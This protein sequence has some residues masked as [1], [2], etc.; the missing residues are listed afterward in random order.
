MV[1]ATESTSVKARLRLS[2]LLAT[3]VFLVMVASDLL[4]L[5]TLDFARPYLGWRDAPGLPQAQVTLGYYLGE[6]TIPFY[7]IAF[8]HLSLAIRPPWSWASRLV[9]AT[10]AYS[11]CL[12]MVWHASFAFTRSI[13]RAELAT[14]AVSAGPHPEAQLAFETYAVPLFRV[15]LLGVAIAFLLVFGL[16]LLGRT[17]YPR[18][19]GIVLPAAFVGVVFLLDPYVPVWAGV[20]LGAAGWNVGGAALCALSTALLWNRGT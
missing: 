17:L 5:T 20:V 3:A 12:F 2:G 4:M 9:L 18:W 6:L 10:S 8:W 15:G 19:A 7:F 14:G 1:N 16:A 11:V 13:V